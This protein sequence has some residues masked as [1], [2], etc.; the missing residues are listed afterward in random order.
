MTNTST[1]TSADGIPAEV[2]Q[3]IRIG[4]G[5]AVYQITT[6]LATE[7]VCLSEISRR[8]RTFSWATQTWTVLADGTSQR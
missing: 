4:N 3:R 2:G 7:I 6:I 1:P 8:W 5:Q